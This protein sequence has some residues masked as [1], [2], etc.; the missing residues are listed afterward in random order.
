[1][2]SEY[3]KDNNVS[4]FTISDIDLSIVNSIRRTILTNIDNVAFHFNVKHKNPEESGIYIKENDSPLHNE[5]LAQRISMIPIHLTSEQIENWNTDDYDFE[6]NVEN[7]SETFKE[8]T[9]KDI[10][11]KYKNKEESKLRDQM[12]PKNKITGDYIIITK[13]PP[14]KD[15]TKLICSLKADKGTAEESACWATTSL[16]TFY[17][18]IDENINKKNLQKF[19]EKNEKLSEKQA[20]LRYN[21]LEYQR[22]FHKNEF[23]EPDKFVFKLESECM[24]SPEE[25]FSQSL[26]YL[27]SKIDRLINFDEDKI[28]VSNE[29]NFYKIILN[30]ETH[31]I[32]NLLQSLMYN[33]H[34]REKRSQFISFVGYFVPHP[35][36]KRVLM[37]IVSTLDDTKFK[38][39]LI[40]TFKTI[41]ALLENV[42]NE[43][44]VFSKEFS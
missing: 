40:E 17:N 7:N 15:T 3:S 2:F 32:G 26:K 11:V 1:M 20:T 38:D 36:E 10:I 8:V 13:L 12:F 35:L 22:A 29:D 27:I 44:L 33:I 5:F 18:Q 19:I 41:K 39:E 43:W 28:T 23:N 21:T 9:T 14:T 34:V 16:C 30:E 6:I 31:T 4:Q 25:I 37:K 24:L 42:L